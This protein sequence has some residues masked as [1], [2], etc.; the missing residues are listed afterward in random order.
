MVLYRGASAFK[1]PAAYSCCST[2]EH[3]AQGGAL[4]LLRSQNPF[5][6]R[7]LVLTLPSA[8]NTFVSSLEGE[9]ILIL[10]ISGQISPAQKGLC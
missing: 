1:E 3:Q 8:W 2:S 7:F 10:Y 6:R 5:H 4:F 9:F